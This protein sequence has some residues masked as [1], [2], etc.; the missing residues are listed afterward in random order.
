METNKQTI[1]EK[2]QQTINETNQQTP[3]GNKLTKIQKQNE[4]N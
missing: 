2:N 1:N 4:K 3:N